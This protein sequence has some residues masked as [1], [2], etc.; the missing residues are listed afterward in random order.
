MLFFSGVFAGSFILGVVSDAMGRK[1]TLYFSLILMLGSTMSL[2]WAPNYATYVSLRFLVGASCAGIFITA[3]V[4][5]MEFMGP[6]TRIWAGMVKNYF[7]A[8]GQLA[9]GSISYAVR[10]WKYI[11]LICGTSCAAY[12][13]YW[14]IIPESPRWLVSKRRLEEAEAILHKAAKVNKVALP[15]ILFDK[16]TLNTKV[17]EGK[18]W[19]IFSSRVLLLRTLVIF[20]NW[21]V[22]SMVFYGLS[23]NTGNLGGD[24][25]LNF[26]I[27]GLVEF[28]AVTL[29][30]LLLNRLGRK[31]LHCGSMLLG[32]FACLISM[33]TVQYGGDELQPLTVTLAMIGKLG[34]S[35]AFG[36]IYIFSAEL[37]PTV[38][39]NTSM[40]ACSCCARIGGMVAPYVVDLGR[41][42]GGDF[43]RGLPLLVFGGASV[44][45]GVFSLFLP[46]TLNSNLPETIE[47]G[48]QLGKSGRRN[49]EVYINNGYSGDYTS[50]LSIN[51]T[52]L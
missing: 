9:V 26:I 38:V 37:Y 31:K 16:D 6:S 11:E 49:K 46:E 20:F 17:P 39:R 10:D 22:V 40:G 23:L 19:D 44:A 36:I 45:A 27:S 35:A 4:I 21:M 34:S 30:I 1:K 13:L 52:K 43:R 33:F 25:Y 12:L 7:F 14:W 15:K 18:L 50:E 5:S 2:T 32:G 24:F 28:P 3:F 48:I 51:D 42:I 29:C 8:L 41:L 47:D